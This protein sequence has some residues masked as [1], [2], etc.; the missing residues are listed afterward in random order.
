MFA[1][2]SN[3]DADNELEQSNKLYTSSHE[4]GHNLAAELVAAAAAA[5]QSLSA[6]V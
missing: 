3:G 5:A 2:S 1:H 4:T 6:A